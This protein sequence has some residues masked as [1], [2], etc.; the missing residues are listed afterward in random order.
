MERLRTIS[1][2]LFAAT[3][4]VA[5]LGT[6]VPVMLDR[7][8]LLGGLDQLACILVL[9][10]CVLLGPPALKAGPPHPG[11]ILCFFAATVCLALLIA[12]AWQV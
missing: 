11:L 7:P 10:V 9:L 8:L 4:L 2:L 3:A 12:A 1:V 5:G 6:A